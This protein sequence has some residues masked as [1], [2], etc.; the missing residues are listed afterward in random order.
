VEGRPATQ[1][2]TPTPTPTPRT[3]IHS[4]RDLP[5]IGLPGERRLEPGRYRLTVGGV[6]ITFAVPAGWTGW[7]LGAT[8]TGWVSRPPEGRLLGFWNVE[9]VYADPCHWNRGYLDGVGAGVDDLVAALEAQPRPITRTPDRVRL[10]GFKGITMEVQV[11]PELDLS[12]C[13]GGEYRSWVDPSGGVR[14]HQRARHESGQ[15]DRLG[16]STSTASGLVIDASYFPS[17]RKPG[18][19]SC[20]VSSTPY[21]SNDAAIRFQPLTTHRASRNLLGSVVNGRR[22]HCGSP[23]PSHSVRSSPPST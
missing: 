9:R 5:T 10:N 19:R 8:D 20:S 1:G 3:T 2:P 12:D 13:W 22:Q 17:T 21:G 15:F 6:R 16:S 11:P 4:P 18:A 23:I 7:T 14:Y